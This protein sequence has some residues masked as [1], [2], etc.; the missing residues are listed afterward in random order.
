MR[1]RIGR[2]CVGR[3]VVTMVLAGG[4]VVHGAKRARAPWF[5]VDSPVDLAD[6][7]PGDGVCSTTVDGTGPCTLRAA[8]QEASALAG[9]DSITV[10][11]GTYTL[12]I[13][14][15]GDDAGV[16]GDLDVTGADDLTITGAGAA[17][18][19]ITGVG[20]RVLDAP[21]PQFASRRNDHASRD[22][23][24][25]APTSENGG[26]IRFDGVGALTVTDSTLQGNTAGAGGGLWVG[27]EATITMDEVVV[28]S[29][30][31][32]GG[33]QTTMAVACTSRAQ[34]R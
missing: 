12:T 21:D 25:A 10:P 26:G 6:A 4:L 2:I 32:I 27:G 33:V 1:V 17:S 8:I 19:V 22:H 16:T 30:R 7:T 13:T 34:D 9:P 14:G 11:A 29:N 15:A 31:A 5:V 20:D 23:W 3:A 24:C 28:A 18:T